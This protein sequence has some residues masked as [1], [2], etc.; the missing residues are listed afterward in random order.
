M[1]TNSVTYLSLLNRIYLNDKKGENT[2][3]SQ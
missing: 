3:R 1:E 2:L